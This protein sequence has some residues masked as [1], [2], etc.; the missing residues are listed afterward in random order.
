MTAFKPCPDIIQLNGQ[1]PIASGRVRDVWPRPG[2]DDE[3]L[4][5][6]VERKRSEYAA[7]RGL[8]GWLS[9]KLLGPY[10]TFWIEYKEYARVAHR[11][12]ESGRLNPIV[13]IGGLV[14][15]D[16]G[17]AQVCKRARGV[18]GGPGRTLR[19]ILSS[20]DMTVDLTER[21]SAFAQDIIALNVNA[22][23]LSTANVMFDA[24]EDRFVLVD[25]FGDKTIVPVRR[26]LPNANQRRLEHWLS[27]YAQNILRWDSATQTFTL[28]TS[29]K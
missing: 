3:I 15:T 29:L 28:R 5:T 6:I 8:L 16:R 19:E 4:K 21:L 23:D 20:G 25:G 7:R 10:R 18:D 2:H 24:V 17:L 27:R 1:T 11:A 13:E 22:P 26:I 9:Q 12:I 14:Q